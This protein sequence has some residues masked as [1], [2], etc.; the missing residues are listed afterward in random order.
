MILMFY[1]YVLL[2]TEESLQWEIEKV[3]KSMVS[4]EWLEALQQT[5]DEFQAIMA[6]NVSRLRENFRKMQE[7]ASK[8]VLS[9]KTKGKLTYT[10]TIIH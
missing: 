4:M 10:H 6:Y 8:K 3:E 1:M 7:V 5:V 9:I 2:L